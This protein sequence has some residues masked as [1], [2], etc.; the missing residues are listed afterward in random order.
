MS[1]IDY[2]YNIT[3]ETIPDG[4]PG[5]RRTIERMFEIAHK[6]SQSWDVICLARKIVRGVESKD[7][8]GEIEAIYR[9]VKDNITFRSDPYG[10]ELLQDPRIVL[11]LVPSDGAYAADCDD[12]SIAVVAL[13]K[14]L[15]IP[16]RFVTIGNSESFTH[17]YPELYDKYADKW[18]ALDL[19][20]QKIETYLDWRPLALKT[21]VWEEKEVCP[22]LSDLG[23]KWWEYVWMV[24]DYVSYNQYQKHKER[25]ALR[26]EY[27][28]WK[29][30]EAKSREE[31]KKLKK[32]YEEEL[33]RVKKMQAW[34]SYQSLMLEF[35]KLQNRFSEEQDMIKARLYVLEQEILKRT[36]NTKIISIGR[37]AV[38]ALGTILLYKLV[39]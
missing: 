35:L 32:A 34:A 36:Q 1:K 22:Q 29:E 4:E 25:E 5:T 10:T 19:T 8:S 6:G 18:I 17:V 31:Y 38:S 11:G 3:Y 28:K 30:F 12:L 27:E 9:Y 2:N 39:A 13:G 33:K 16:G 24:A 37:I 20:P 23:K 14:A 7:K 15:G 26:E 21:K